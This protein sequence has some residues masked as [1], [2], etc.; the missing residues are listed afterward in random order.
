M[1]DFTVKLRVTLGKASGRSALIG[2]IYCIGSLPFDIKNRVSG[3]DMLDCQRRLHLM[4][5][6]CRC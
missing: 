2:T 6:L 3:D 5:F 1:R 4:N